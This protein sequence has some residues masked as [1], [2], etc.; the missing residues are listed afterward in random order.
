MKRFFFALTVS[1]VG[2]T[3]V[4]NADE[5]FLLM[6]ILP[7]TVNGVDTAKVNDY[8]YKSLASCAADA[9]R[10]VD[11]EQAA[12]AKGNVLCVYIPKIN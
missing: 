8:V 10:L 9:G 5:S 4:A 3:S 11:R 12:H 2:L 7:G 1:T 6:N